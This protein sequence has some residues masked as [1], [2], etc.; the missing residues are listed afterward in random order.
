MVVLVQIFRIF[1]V[2]SIGIGLNGF[3]MVYYII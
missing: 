3:N 2:E 1:Q